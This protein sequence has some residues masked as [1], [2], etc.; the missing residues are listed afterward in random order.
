LS[1]SDVSRDRIHQLLLI[2]DP[3]F[4]HH[5]GFD[6]ATPGAGLTTITQG[7]VKYLYFGRFKPGF[8][9]IEQTL[10]AWLAVN[11]LVRK[12][13]QL[14]VFINTAYLGTCEKAEVRGFSAAAKIYFGKPFHTLTDD[15]YLSLVAMLIG[16]DEFSVKYRPG[17]NR[18][19]VERIRKVLSGEYKPQ[20]LRDVYYG[21][22]T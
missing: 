10:I 9:K 5:R 17:R 7:M 18:E 21:Q 16:P 15:E 12:D 4:Y 13:D 6:F 14:T 2:E 1:L 19:R 11:T 8:M 3:D 20:G 22:S